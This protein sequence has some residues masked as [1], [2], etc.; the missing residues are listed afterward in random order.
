MSSQA[1]F[2]TFYLLDDGL[3]YGCGYNCY[4]Q[5]GLGHT[6]NQPTLQCLK[7]PKDKKAVDIAAAQNHTLILS[8]DGSVYG[9]G[10][11]EYGQLGL[12]HKTNQSTLQCLRLPQGRKALK[13][14]ANF[15]HT[16]F[17]LDDGL[18]YGC[19]ENGSGQLG[20][21]HKISQS[22]LQC[23]ALPEG[24]KVLY[25]SAG[26]LHT[27]FLLDDGSVYGCGSNSFGQ[28]GLGHKND[29]STLQRLTLPEGKKAII[30][31]AGLDNTL[32]L[33]NDG[34]IY[35]CGSNQFGK[36]GLDIGVAI[37]EP[38]LL[39]ISLQALGKIAKDNAIQRAEKDNQSG[40]TMM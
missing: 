10:N 1:G 30:I 11:N 27:F 36:L 18:V 37:L 19:G 33:L 12:G 34:S 28:L 14:A 24:K 20:L 38:T 7:L 31:T 8:K 17:L 26:N 13:I 32:I 5:L 2:H 21:G 16:F 4:G 9:C 23:M 39:T 22:T 35:G 29:Q 40:C 6:N 25:I 3:V 15:Y